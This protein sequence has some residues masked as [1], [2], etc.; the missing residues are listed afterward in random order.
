ML[1]FEKR[2]V[3]I[4]M[5][6]QVI[7][8]QDSKGNW[9]ILRGSCHR[10]GKCCYDIAGKKGPCDQLKSEIVNNKKVYYCNKQVYPEGLGKPWGCSVWPRYVEEPLPLECGFYWELEK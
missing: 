8:A 3:L 5:N 4:N 2:Q 10:C 9:W 7:K 6:G 1:P